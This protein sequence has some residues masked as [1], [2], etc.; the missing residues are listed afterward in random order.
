MW[1]IEIQTEPNLDYPSVYINTREPTLDQLHI[2]WKYRSE[3]HALNVDFI[4]GK[5]GFCDVNSNSI[6]AWV[7]SCKLCHG[8]T[9][10]DTES[11]VII[12][13]VTDLATNCL[14]LYFNRMF[15]LQMEYKALDLW[16]IM[17]GSRTIH[18]SLNGHKFNISLECCL[19]TGLNDDVQACIHQHVC[20]FVRIDHGSSSIQATPFGII[21]RASV[22]RYI[23]WA[24][25]Q[26]FGWILWDVEHAVEQSA[27]SH[28]I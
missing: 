8:F 24:K 11:M 5:L 12:W 13:K 10:D 15:F 18:D 2:K 23:K 16:R 4:I 20:S 7:S 27:F 28:H 6:M 3:M 17:N 22:K 9:H 19:C 1:R 21:V 25:I 26:A 14:R